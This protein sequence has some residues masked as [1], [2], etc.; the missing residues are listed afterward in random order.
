MGDS[1]Y[2]HEEIEKK[3]Q[4]FWQENQSFKAENEKSGTKEPFYVL[5][6]FPYPSGAG[7]HVGHPLGYIASDI[8]ARYKRHVGYNVLHP[9]GYDSFG[10]PAEQYAIQ[11]GQHP[12]K[13]TEQNIAR[14]R[15][16]LDKIG[17]SFD[18]DREVRTSDPEYYNWTQYIFLLFFNSWY[19][20]D[21]N[22]AENIQTL[23]SRFESKGSEGL[24]TKNSEPFSAQQWKGF[25]EKQKQDTLMNFRLAY[26]SEA[27]V[28][29]CPALGTVLANDEV[30]DGLSERG[31]YPV[32]R[33]KMKQW[34]MR[35]TAY[36]D[37]LLQDLEDVDWNENIKEIQRNWIG[38]SEGTGVRYHLTP[39]PS[40]QGEG[41]GW[42]TTSKDVNGDSRNE[43]KLDEGNGWR[44]KSEDSE[45]D[46]YEN[47]N[48]EDNN[49]V[50]EIDHNQFYTTD[51]QLWNILIEKAKSMRTNPT[52]AEWILW[53][54]IRNCALG[55]KFRRQH[56]IDRFIVDFA[57][58]SKMLV[59]EVDGDIH[60]LQKEEDE[61]RSS[62]L[63]KH[64]FKVIRF[65]NEEIIN[66]TNKVISQIKQE[67]ESLPTSY[68][69]I[70]SHNTRII[71]SEKKENYSK[72]EINSEKGEQNI[73]PI[74]TDNSYTS[75]NTQDSSSP[76]NEINSEKGGQNIN[77]LKTDNSH[78]TP[79][80]QD[81]S[82]PTNEINLEKGEQ[83]IN[84]IKSD[85]SH[86]TPK[87]QDSSSPLSL[88]RGAGGEVIE[89]FTTRPD[90]LFGVSYLT[91]AP[92]H[93]LVLKITT[94]DRRSKV[95]AYIEYA[96]SRSERD[97][98]TEVKKI[99]GEFTGAYVTH[100]FSGEEIPVWVGEYV[101]AGYG[102]GAVMAVPAHDE[103]DFAFAKHFGLPIKQVIEAPE[104]WDINKEPWCEKQGKVFNSDFLNGLEVKEAIS[105]MI[106][107]IEASYIGEGKT[108]Y[109]LRDAVFGRQRYWGE[110]IPVYYK[111]GI[112]YPVAEKHLPLIL[113]EVDKFLPTESG[114]PPLG[115]AGNWNYNPDKGVVA[116][117]DG[118]PLE[119]T[120][121]P[122]WAGS[123]WYFF[124]YMDAKNPTEFADRNALD[125]WKNVDFYVGGA[126][127]ATGH[128]LYSRF[129]TKFLFDIGLVGVKEPFK[130]M[131]NQGMILGE[132]AFIYRADGE[133]K[134]LSKNQV[135]NKKTH[136][137]RVDLSVIDDAH[138]ELN[139]EKIKKHPLY[140]DYKDFE[141]V[142]ESNGK[143]IVEREVEKMSKSKYNVVN[144][145][146]ICHEYGA[147]TLRMYEMFLGPIEDAKPWS[148]KGIEGVYKF[149]RKLWR[150]FY[151]EQ[152][153]FYLSE[154]KPNE[155]EFKTLHK[156][157]KKVTSDIESLSFNTSVS[158][159]MICVN[160]LQELKCNKRQV[161]EPLLILLSPFAPHIC[162]ELWE[163]CRH[164]G[165]ISKVTWPEFKEE[166]LTES[167]ITYPISVNG[168]TRAQITVP[169][170]AGKD[171]VEK[172]VL[173]N[174]IV[175]KWMEGK[176]LKKFIFVPGKIVNVV[177]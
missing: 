158:A 86:L 109:R 3:W 40:P 124:R 128:L 70:Q 111:D 100:P 38:K 22:K 89:V 171:E 16:Q 78:L 106:E 55:H 141:F 103:R 18:W 68:P 67:L 17:F 142:T 165:G 168:K 162:E 151:N 42:R 15:E 166:Y 21:S 121:M 59:V 93:D 1:N 19:N 112:A 152:E 140:Q 150:L 108:N 85:N 74:K 161:L 45:G 9:M 136:L 8:V 57:C 114:E 99:T 14:Y 34:S 87:T 160:E 97:R 96:K 157:I 133:N 113:P 145:D 30:K 37:R 129:W 132:S 90:T 118:Y 105:R 80:T 159:F 43:K 25:S 147:D 119:L 153:E 156:T 176:T 84:P 50:N 139:I 116:N 73:N 72:N 175:Q 127:H 46:S 7:L 155:K 56:I 75:P 12:A 163:K 71:V 36:A 107:E 2:K 44:T 58:L 131:L 91:L 110:P 146:D 102:T 5:D 143:F 148:T 144:P 26:L 51:G 81:S 95:E 98:Q 66:Q 170:T 154:E 101:L 173:A 10:L 47:R 123:S 35:I 24:D 117:G 13:T 126:E 125:Y 48:D 54:N 120:T 92:E 64:G 94:P 29:W 31:G 41:D 115:R 174:E 61:I 79:N 134:L 4:K 167:N 60:D 33:K 28:N 53:Q 23:I 20:P 177:V 164:H 76:T 130:K 6:M 39:N 135:H 88:R 62:I 27:F 172:L 69:N 83:N 122:G 63:S 149:L 32:E 77:P 65:R 137:I 11:T 82:S 52:K 169:A 104:G 138:N 49:V